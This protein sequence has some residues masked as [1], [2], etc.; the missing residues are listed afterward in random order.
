MVQLP[1]QRRLRRVSSLLRN[2]HTALLGGAIVIL[3]VVAA[4]FAPILAPHDPRQFNVRDRHQPPSATYWLGTDAYGRDIASRLMFGARV[5]ILV[6]VTV[7]LFEALVGVTV[8]LIA[9]YGGKRADAL[10]MRVTDV[11]MSIPGILLALGIMAI[12]GPSFGNIVFALAVRGWTSFA[13]LVRSETLSL[14]ERDFVTGARALGCS[15]ARIIVRHI[16]PNLAS[17]V[18][19]FASLRIA[20]PILSETALSYLGL[21]LPLDVISWG[22]MIRTDQ[23]YLMFVWWPVTFP[24]LA[25][26]V[27]VLGFN[28]LGDGIRDLLDPKTRRHD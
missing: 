19:V 12:R 11:F 24:G 16:L 5:S 20:T 27:T 21:G 18:V 23:A 6:G 4:V 25:I 14:K 2:H 7:V 22:G 28:L 13:R 17:T 26:M 3:L 10:I 15:N 9:G 1:R 8:G